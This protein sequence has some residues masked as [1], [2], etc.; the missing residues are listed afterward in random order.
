[1]GAT[2]KDII[3]ILEALRKSGAMHAEVIVQ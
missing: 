2:T 3:S 1:V